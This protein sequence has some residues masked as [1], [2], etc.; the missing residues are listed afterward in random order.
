MSRQGDY[1]SSVTPDRLRITRSYKIK[2]TP[3]TSVIRKKTIGYKVNPRK[4]E[5]EDT[6]TNLENDCLKKRLHIFDIR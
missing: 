5:K 4:M 1:L 3:D 2:K 6:V